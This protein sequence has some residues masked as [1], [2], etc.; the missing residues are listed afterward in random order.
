MADVLIPSLI[1]HQSPATA[2]ISGQRLLPSGA[3]SPQ[4]ASM[5][6]FSKHS[7]MKQIT[8]AQKARYGTKGWAKNIIACTIFVCECSTK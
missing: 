1:L 4:V 8:L 5:R 7:V 2:P 3:S 6:S